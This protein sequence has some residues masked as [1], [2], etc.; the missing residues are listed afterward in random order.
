MARVSIT[1]LVALLIGAAAGGAGV[2]K[3][4]GPRAEE[5]TRQERRLALLNEENGRLRAVVGEQEKKKSLAANTAQRETIE[6][7]VVVI[8]GLDF[9]QPVAYNVLNRQEIKQTI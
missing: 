8:R 7:E 2:W 3:Y 5:A 6:R 1:A 9:K 4:L